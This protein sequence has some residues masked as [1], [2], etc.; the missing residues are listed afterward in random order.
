MGA[1]WGER[2]GRNVNPFP[3]SYKLFGNDFSTFR[4]TKHRN[5]RKGKD[6]SGES[7]MNVYLTFPGRHCL[8]RQEPRAQYSSWD[9]GPPLPLVSLA[10]DWGADAPSDLKVKADSGKAPCEDK[11]LP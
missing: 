4:K 6:T 11:S 3:L 1:G 7:L 10:S 9:P 5:D 2:R 8:G